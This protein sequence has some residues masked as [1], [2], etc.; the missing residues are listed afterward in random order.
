[1]TLDE[2]LDML[3]TLLDADGNTS[4]KLE[5]YLQIA[6]K[7]I[8]SWRYSY[9]GHIPDTLPAEYESTQIYAVIAGF[10]LSGAENQTQHTENGIMRAFKHSD[11]IA[12]IRSHVIPMAG[13]F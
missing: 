5:A 10:N 2:K 1:M 13:V 11:M 8:L 12:Y 9:T 6:E 7:E 3:T 4:D